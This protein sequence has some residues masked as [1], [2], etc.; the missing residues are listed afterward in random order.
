MIQVDNEH[1]FD[2]I[3]EGDKYV[4]R[5]YG[6]GEVG[7]LAEREVT[8][9]AVRDDL[10][11]IGKAMVA[12][13]LEKAATEAANASKGASRKLII[14]LEGDITELQAL[15]FVREVVMMGRISSTAGRE[16]Y[17]HVSTFRFGKDN[18]EAEV[19]AYKR[20]EGTDTFKVWVRE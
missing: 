20:T 15:N 7:I 1:W 9:E 16:H 12:A 4:A 10:M 14:H 5:L 13:H 11:G 19:S 6:N 18:K 17:C 8:P 2:I 3:V